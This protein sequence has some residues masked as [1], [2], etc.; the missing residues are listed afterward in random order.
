ML[1]SANKIPKRRFSAFQSCQSRNNISTQIS[2]D[3]KNSENAISFKHK[4]SN[5]GWINLISDITNSLLNNYCT[6]CKLKLEE[7]VLSPIQK[8]DNIIFETPSNLLE[9]EVTESSD[10]FDTNFKAL[11][12][13]GSLKRHGRRRMSVNDIPTSSNNIIERRYSRVAKL[14]QAGR[15]DLLNNFRRFSKPK[16]E[17]GEVASPTACAATVEFGVC[18]AEQLK[19]TRYKK[20]VKINLIFLLL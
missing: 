18:L 6:N 15:E 7:A 14:S 17:G 19:L 11:T 12:N 8:F 20:K 16:N 9:S 1:P 13:K 3:L 10:K 2:F 5:C 4:C